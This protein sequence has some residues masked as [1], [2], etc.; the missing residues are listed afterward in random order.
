MPN[1][2]FMIIKCNAVIKTVTGTVTGRQCWQ[3]NEKGAK[4]TVW[5]HHPSQSEC[6]EISI[7]GMNSLIVGMNSWLLTTRPQCIGYPVMCHTCV[8][9]YVRWQMT[10]WMQWCH[11]RCHSPS[12]HV[13]G[14]HQ[15]GPQWSG[16]MTRWAEAFGSCRKQSTTWFCVSNRRYICTITTGALLYCNMLGLW[17][18]V[19]TTLCFRMPWI[20]LDG[21]SR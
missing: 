18:S 14:I 4:V 3:K 16:S 21:W 10:V 19:N 17:C 11:S 1:Y 15:R 12:A 6:P 13:A 20:L 9:N 5:Q 8:P 7:D 2:G